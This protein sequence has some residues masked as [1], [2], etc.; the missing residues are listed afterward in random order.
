[1]R[2]VKIINPKDDSLIQQL[3][4][5]YS[6]FKNITQKERVNFDF[7]ELKWLFPL[8]VLPTSVY[9]KETQSGFIPPTDSKVN[10]YLKT[11]CFPKGISQ[12]AE[13]Q[14]R[15]SY[16]PIGVL[17][18]KGDSQEKEKLESCFAEMIYKILEPTVA[19]QSAVYY[20]LTELVTNIF[21]H[22]KKDV[23]YI[24]GQYY[25]K[26][27]FL[28]LCIVDCG[29][30]LTHS[31]QEDEGLKFSDKEAIKQA[32]SGRS[33]KKDLERGYGI[34]TSKRVVCE[35]LAGNFVLLSGDTA[36]YSSKKENKLIS[37]PGFYWQ[38]VI[39]AYRILKPK[40]A[41]DIAPFIEG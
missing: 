33:T 10:S 39:V 9:I 29:R 34:R 13:L 26:K 30:G 2:T 14:K 21:E 12:V 23:G 32:L 22:S 1:M 16:I 7:S 20:P 18:K 15:S 27:N 4:A 3:V 35:G 25:P 40:G 24:F 41:V 5:L 11:I 38:G 31:Y 17:E 37:F 36:L 6:V 8:L 19:A 28:D